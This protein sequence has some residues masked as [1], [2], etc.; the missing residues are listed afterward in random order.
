MKTR[1]VS[2]SCARA[3]CAAT[4]LAV[5]ALFAAEPRVDI[6]SPPDA[7]RF[8]PPATIE[9]TAVATDPDGYVPRAELIVGNQV[10]DVSSI[11]FIVAPTNGTPIQHSFRWSGVP[12]GSYTY[13]VRATNDSQDQGSSEPRTLVVA[14]PP[15]AA[16]SLQVIDAEAAESTQGRLGTNTALFR[17]TRTGD[18]SGVL[19]VNLAREGSAQ[20]GVDYLGVPE[21]LRFPAGSNTLDVL[22]TPW[23][24]ALAEESEAVR[25]S[26][27]PGELYS[28]AAPSTASATIAN[29]SWEDRPSL[30][31]V[32]PDPAGAYQYPTN[33]LLRVEASGWDGQLGRV[34]FREGA[35][36]LGVRESAPYE[37]I[38]TNTPAGSHVLTARATDKA[39]LYTCDSPPVGISVQGPIPTPSLAFVAPTNGS[40]AFVGAHVPIRLRIADRFEQSYTVVITA[41][42]RVLA[43][44]SGVRSECAV[45][46]VFYFPGEITL[47]ATALDAAGRVV[48]ATPVTLRIKD[49]NVQPWARLVSPER[50]AQVPGSRE[51]AVEVLA[52][53]LDGRVQSVQVFLDAQQVGAVNQPVSESTNRYRVTLQIP[54]GRHVLRAHAIDNAGA[55]G[56][57]SPVVVYVDTPSQPEPAIRLAEQPLSRSSFAIGA[58]GTLFQWDFSG[59]AGI[60][61]LITNPLPVALPPAAGRLSSFSCGFNNGS[62]LIEG[63][64]LD[65]AGGLTR[66]LTRY[67]AFGMVPPPEGVTHWSSVSAGS[68]CQ[69][70]IGG[71]GELYAWG[72]NT[73]GVL[74]LGTNA[75][76][77]QIVAHPTRVPRPAGVRGWRQISA[78][79]HVLAIDA[80]GRLFA[81]GRNSAGQLGLG[82]NPTDMVAVPQRV[83]APEGL[84]FKQVAAGASHSLALASTGDLY[85][86]GTNGMGQL[87]VGRLIVRSVS[88]IKLAQP[89]GITRW[90]RLAAGANHSL[91]L[92]DDGALFGWGA[93]NYGQVGPYSLSSM[94][95]GRE[96]IPRR[97]EWPDGAA[98][99]IAFSAGERHSLAVADDARIFA[100]GRTHDS[101]ANYAM[102]PVPGAT[103]DVL[104]NSTNRPPAVELTVEPTDPAVI[105]P[106]QPVT[107]RAAA[108]DP[109]SALRRVDFFDGTTLLASD[110]TLPYVLTQGFGTLG[111]HELSARAV[112]AQGAETWSQPVV[113][114]VATN[115][116][117]PKLWVTAESPS[118]AEIA[119]NAVGLARLHR[120]GDTREPLTVQ[121]HV[122]GTATVGLDYRPLGDGFTFK[123][124]TSTLDIPVFPIA[125]HVVEPA[126]TVILTLIASTN[127]LL[128]PPESATITILDSPP[129]PV[130]AA[131]V[132]DLPDVFVPGEALIAKVSARPPTGAAAW[133]VE[134]VLPPGWTALRISDDGV[135]DALKGKVKFGP[136]FRSEAR[137]LSYELTAPAGATNAVEFSG[138]ASVD[139][140]NSTVRGDRILQPGALRHPADQA[141]ADFSLQLAELTGY[142]AA[143]RHGT[144]WAV[145]PNPIPADYVTRAGLLWRSG[146]LYHFNGAAGAPPICWMPGVDGIRTDPGALDYPL[147]GTGTRGLSA[148]APWVV[149]LRIEPA[150]GVSNYAVE[151]SLPE[152]AS[153]ANISHDGLWDAAARK[154][155]WGPY[156]DD[157]ARTLTYTVNFGASEAA[158]ALAGVASLDGRSVP[159]GGNLLVMPGANG[160]PWLGVERAG[161]GALELLVFGAIGRVCQVEG[162]TDGV[163]WELMNT[164]QAGTNPHRVPV[165][166]PLAS[167]LRFYRL[168]TAP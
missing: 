166:M 1:T 109:D 59:V 118:V 158:Q 167:A 165:G 168:R 112:D 132:R 48:T 98:E 107:L 141:E 66:W 70:G 115:Q 90:M 18:L 102:Q 152:G 151:E 88:P 50:H 156:Y 68:A 4:L 26:L 72:L 160:R 6:L 39:R 138:T 128:A 38:W 140:V 159:I 125:D 30:R 94:N 97:V 84:S 8:A 142:A 136:F 5:N 108:S 56:T 11:V 133:A 153:V 122:S 51:I 75:T 120:S 85:A 9:V 21:I 25:F 17:L 34:E 47:A 37:M 164:V 2:P 35:V 162:S 49:E 22:V 77:G 89:P 76:P 62:P 40:V 29:R 148:T 134:E 146:E 143:W 127:Y 149:S 131:F 144:R 43:T 12:A 157:T 41:D 93:N 147:A 135:W 145:G 103:R 69:F 92:A 105:L 106:N 10:V 60:S 46:N 119:M 44:T 154:V 161:D 121:I 36:L 15:P 126:E 101:D 137:V 116:Q 57:S 100:W 123:A 139:G 31:L 42:G 32:S 3:C 130:E 7:A 24:D 45:T 91:A 28:V 104:S 63:L 27:L 83:T 19:A 81:W 155:R 13:R 16:V 129:P 53:D 64:A 65:A 117:L 124:G 86:W 58:G 23:N 87:G 73:S 61:G 14:P 54:G 99:W 80:D 79:S 78:T 55:R 110:S 96:F 114:M 111:R 163:N 20:N 82:G 52:G 67:A 71:D 95:G 113:L 74:G 150:A 33:L